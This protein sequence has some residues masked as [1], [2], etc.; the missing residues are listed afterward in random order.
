MAAEISNKQEPRE[1]TENL[2]VAPTSIHVDGYYKGFHVGIAQTDPSKNE[3]TFLLMRNAKAIIDL[4][5]KDG[6]SPG[7]TPET[8]KQ[9]NIEEELESK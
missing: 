5:E 3:E 1:E 9:Q 6:W 7:I 2:P 8:T 4:M